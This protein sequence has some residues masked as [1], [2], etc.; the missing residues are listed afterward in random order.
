MTTIR[1]ATSDDIDRILHLNQ[2][3]FAT[4]SEALERVRGVIRIERWLVAEQRGTVVAAAQTI[5]MAHFFG[6]RPVPC[7]GIASVAVAAEA[8]G[9]G[10]GSAIMREAI[11]H[12][13]ARGSAISSLYPATMPIYRALGY[14]FGFLFTVWE[15]DLRDLPHGRGADLEPFDESAIDEIDATYRRF[16]ATQAGLIERPRDWW[17][18][19]VLWKPW[20]ASTR[21][22]YLVRE[23]GA[24][25]GWASYSYDGEPGTFALQFRDLMWTT[26][27]AARALLSLA[28][29][30]RST[31]ARIEWVGAPDE[32]LVYLFHD[33][34]PRVRHQ[35]R[36]MLRLLDVPAAL[37]ARG[38][39]QHVSA[40]VTIEVNDPHLPDNA[41]PWHVMVDGGSAKVAPAS[42]AVARADASAWASMYSGLLRPRDA[43]RT[44]LLDASGDALDSLEAIFAGPMP[45]LAD[46]F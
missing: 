43:V 34:K 2:Q 18:K 46:Y 3:A 28:S 41:G 19:R 10:V 6:A 20:D 13:R 16:A 29:L 21:Y 30:H 33:R 42:D 40:S 37:E 26:P 17:E 23:E 5:P 4:P 32:G 9:R 1:P 7:A 36:A 39:Q 8:R 24:V 27:E 25:T 45:W 44:G 35:E 12:A 14:G 38:Y 22:R 11:T 31:A 15:A